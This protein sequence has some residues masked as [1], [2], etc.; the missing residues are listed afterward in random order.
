M[1]ICVG[2]LGGAVALATL[3]CDD[4]PY[5]GAREIVRVWHMKLGDN[6]CFLHHCDV[7]F[8]SGAE[9]KILQFL[10]LKWTSR[11]FLEIE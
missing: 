6:C 3:T 8:S 9:E 10:L 1:A 2:S 5:S 7:N 11:V 4:P